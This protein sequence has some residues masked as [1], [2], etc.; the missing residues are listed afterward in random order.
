M[1]VRTLVAAALLCCAQIAC[2]QDKPP[3]LGTIAFPTSGSGDAR[4][5]F[6]TG[7]LA[8][9]SFW[10]EEARDHFRKAQQLDSTFGMAYWGEAMSYDNALQTQSGQGNEKAGEAVVARL[11]QL[12]GKKTLRWND[13]ERGFLQAIRERFQPGRDRDARRQAYADSMAD[14]AQKYPEDDE[15]IAFTAVAVMGVPGY[16]IEDP[17]NVVAIA[18]RLEQI[19][20]RNPQHPGALHYLI[21]VYDSPTYALMGIRQARLYAQ[22]APASSHALHMPSHIFRQLGMWKEMEKSNEAAFAASVAWQQRTKRPIYM[23]DFHSLDWLLEARLRQKDMAGAKKVIDDVDAMEKERRSKGEEWGRFKE[24][25]S[26]LRAAFA[27]PGDFAPR[28]P[29]E[30]QH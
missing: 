25:A 1:N 3:A 5:E 12:D 6:I 18:G 2:A 14:L 24:Y 11:D 19:F 28:V 7:V 9:H 8:L 29:E 10:Y 27:S 22:I 16:A 21:H 4:K 20:L 26:A 17:G 30:H 13:V 15:V 23:R